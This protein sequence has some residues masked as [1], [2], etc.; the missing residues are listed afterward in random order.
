MDATIKHDVW[1]L[2]PMYKYFLFNQYTGYENAKHLDL[3][4]NACA[5]FWSRE[6]P[7]LLT[8][9]PSTLFYIVWD[10]SSSF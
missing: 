1:G 6:I 9:L 10:S 2:L 7:C 5:F 3:A 8:K 4:E